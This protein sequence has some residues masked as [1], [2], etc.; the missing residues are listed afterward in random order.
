[1]CIAE[2]HETKRKVAIKT[3]SVDSQYPMIIYEANVTLILHGV[4]TN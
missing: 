2:H 3:E 1:M 4:K